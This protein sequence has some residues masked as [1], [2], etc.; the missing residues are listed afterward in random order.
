MDACVIFL[1]HFSV[2]NQSI[3]Q[4]TGIKPAYNVL[5]TM[6][7][8]QYKY[9][10]QSSCTRSATQVP[11]TSHNCLSASVASVN[12]PGRA[13]VHIWVLQILTAS[14]CVPLLGVCVLGGSKFFLLKK[15]QKAC[16]LHDETILR[17][18]F[19]CAGVHYIKT[20]FGVLAFAVDVETSNI[21]T[22][23]WSSLLF[24]SKRGPAGAK[25]PVTFLRSGLLSIPCIY[26]RVQ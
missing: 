10:L 14:N 18:S 12:I 17:R 26:K 9:S 21:S 22:L 13:C 23:T 25:R 4:P 3:Y 8:T 1:A 2:A 16:F 15:E 24:C 6:Y 19:F 11:T 7:S 20:H 5:R